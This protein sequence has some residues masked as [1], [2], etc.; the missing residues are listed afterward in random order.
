[1]KYLIEYENGIV[2]TKTL[3]PHEEYKTW[4]RK[5]KN[6]Y[7]F[8]QSCPEQA[9]K[10]MEHTYKHLQSQMKKALGDYFTDKSSLFDAISTGVLILHKNQGGEHKVKITAL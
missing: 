4:H 5:V 8:L 7:E 3:V 1:M 10:T 9:K 6:A 2:Q